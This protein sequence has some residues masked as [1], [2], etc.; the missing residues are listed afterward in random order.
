MTRFLLR[1]TMTTI[2]ALAFVPFTASAQGEVENFTPITAEMLM[3][4]DPADWVMWR[5]NYASWG[6]SPLDQI[7]QA[8]V[9]DL[10]LAWAWNMVDGRQETTPLVYDGV[11]YLHNQ[12]DRVQALNAATGD[13]IWEYVRNLPG[14]LVTSSSSISR[15]MAL[16]NDKLYFASGDM[17]LVALDP[18]N[19][20]VEWESVMGDWEQ[21]YRVTGGPLVVGDVVVVGVS[22]CGGA[23]PGGC[24]I[25]GHDANT[26]DAL[27]R[28]DTIAAEGTEHDSWNGVPQESRFGGSAWNI[29]S[30]DP[31]LDLVYWGTGQPY[32]WIA[33]M[34]GLLPANPAASNDALYTDTTLALRPATGELVW[35]H[36]WLPTDTWDL[37]Y[38]Y[39]QVLVDLEID[40]ET[41]PALVAV[42]KLGIVEAIDRRTGEWL[43][44][45]ET[46][47]QN[48]V[49]S[50]DPDTG[51]K[52]INPDAVPAI[53]RTTVNCP[54]DPGSRSWAATA[55]SPRTNHLYLPMQE[56]CSDTTPNPVGEGEVYTGGGR[57]TFARRAVP[58]SDGNMGLVVAVGL[59]DVATTWE[60]RMRPAN[61]GSAAL[62][63]GGG[64]VFTGNL[65][66][67]F[68]AFDDT[69][70][71]KLWEVRLS[72]LP[73]GYPISYE[74]DGV[75]YIAVPVGRGSGPSNAFAVL[76]PEIVNPAGGS[77]LFVFRLG[78]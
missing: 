77:V 9:G 35:F 57:A 50:I 56:F 65:G 3:D 51:V 69:T 17:Y 66:R 72:N 10:E 76:T 30:Y 70:G 28:F 6:Y 31:E 58:G 75:Q 24:Y 61:G 48:V 45:T 40:G 43:W 62:T 4:P 25:V 14:E 49:Q 47:Y 1:L 53:G 52:T 18:R 29:G 46:V 13:L 8:N 64:L 44:A 15:T 34:N 78:D 55:Y 60:H 74:V 36:Q 19:G 5:R 27:W 32:P 23:Q 7:T 39:E 71:E 41:V 11:M 37:D 73:N 54:A 26:G 59:D 33:E 38:A 20:Q 2:I 16:A 12:G 63:T 67:Y 68:M 21:S 42:G 22:G